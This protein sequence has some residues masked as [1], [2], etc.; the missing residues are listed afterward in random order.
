[1]TQ[2][3]NIYVDMVGDLFHGNHVRLLKEAKTYGNNLLLGLHSDEEVE[4][5]KKKKP[6]LNVFERAEII[7]SCKYVDKI[8]TLN[9][10]TIICEEFLNKY[11]IDLVI[12]AHNEHEKI[13]DSMFA[14]PIKLNKFK[15]IDYHPGISTTEIKKRIIEKNEIS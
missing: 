2:Y 10:P 14:I 4:K 5:Y 1:M 7:E 12:H 6:I 11:N 15:R 13:Y 8:I 9:A 3:N